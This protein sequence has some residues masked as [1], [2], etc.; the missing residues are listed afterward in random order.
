MVDL[1]NLEKLDIKRRGVD[2]IDNK[3]E[4]DNVEKIASKQ[5]EASTTAVVKDCAY[6]WYY[7]GSRDRW[8]KYR[9]IKSDEIEAAFLQNLPTIETVIQGTTY[10][11]DIGHLQQYQKDCDWKRREI[12]REVVA[13][14]GSDKENTSDAS[15]KRRSG[16]RKVV[17]KKEEPSTSESGDA[18]PSDPD[19]VEIKSEQP[20][21]KDDDIKSENEPGDYH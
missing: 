1:G 4:E 20:A 21:L 7:K 3:G 12:K 16:R 8:Y 18:R 14:E 13:S 17:V 11:I 10:V 2:E 15:S 5:K 6:Q 9:T 19:K